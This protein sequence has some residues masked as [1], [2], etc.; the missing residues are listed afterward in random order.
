[1]A[2]A[3]FS[4]SILLSVKKVVGIHSEYDDFDDN[5]IIFT[6]TVLSYLVQMGIG[7]E[8]VFVEDDLLTW[9]QFLTTKQV[10]LRAVAT[11][12]GLKVKLL[13]DPPQNSNLTQAIEKA[14]D[15]AQWR[16]YITENYVGEI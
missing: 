12:T 7:R 2:E 16:I 9:D 6:N 3:N 15:E 4:D 5:L 11:Y 10:N 14:I 8:G 13:F 1:M